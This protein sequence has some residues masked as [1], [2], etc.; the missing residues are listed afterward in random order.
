MRETVCV[1]I[2]V[3]G[4]GVGGRGLGGGWLCV[5]QCCVWGMCNT[6]ERG[7]SGHTQVSATSLLY[8]RFMLTMAGKW[9]V[10]RTSNSSLDSWIT[11]WW[12]VQVLAHPAWFPLQL[13]HRW[14]YCS[15]LSLYTRLHK[16]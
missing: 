13:H 14:P 4:E 11:C 5:G 9:P 12:S 2:H 15:L 8:H 16:T 1:S 6:G 10:V 7:L 3:C